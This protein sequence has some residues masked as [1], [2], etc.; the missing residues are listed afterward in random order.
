[1]STPASRITSTASRF[2]PTCL[3]PALKT[4]K[5]P[6]ARCRSQPSAIWLRH[7]FPVQRKS[8]RVL[9]TTLACTTG[10]GIAGRS[11]LGKIVLMHHEY[12]PLVA[13]GIRDPALVLQRV[14]AIDAHLVARRQPALH[15]LLANRQ[16]FVGRA[17]LDA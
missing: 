7:E 10:H 2:S 8:T 14:A 17:H 1:M 11:F 15:P 3:V 12:L 6:P 4:S 9:D 13:V 16:H 5:R